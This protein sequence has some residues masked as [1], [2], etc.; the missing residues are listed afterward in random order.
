[1]HVKPTR[2]PTAAVGS[3]VDQSAFGGLICGLPNGSFFTEF[4]ENPLGFFVGVAV[5]LPWVCVCIFSWNFCW[6]VA[7]ACAAGACSAA[8]AE[9]ATVADM[10]T[11]IRLFVSFNPFLSLVQ[12][13]SRIGI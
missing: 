8:A 9:S 1:M 5:T 11:I 2:A 10:A 7:C 13:T 6:A 4:G 12:K 3:S